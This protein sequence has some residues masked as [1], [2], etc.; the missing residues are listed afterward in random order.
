MW[1]KVAPPLKHE[2]DVRLGLQANH[3]EP[4]ITFRMRT[5]IAR[6]LFGRRGAGPA[7]ASDYGE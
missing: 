4:L 3:D 7:T 2:V 6:T 5:A 1:R